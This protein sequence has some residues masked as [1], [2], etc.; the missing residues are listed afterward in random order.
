M[1]ATLQSAAHAFLADASSTIDQAAQNACKPNCGN[2]DLGKLFG[3]IANTLVFIV[4]AIAVIMI[5]VGGL[6]YVLSSGDAKAAA[7]A[8]NTILYSVIGI[9]VAIAAYAIVHFVTSNFK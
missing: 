1:L 9:I 7:D 8:K 3:T 6:R 2:A 5:I 4:G